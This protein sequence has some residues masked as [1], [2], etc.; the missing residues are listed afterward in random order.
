MLPEDKV[1]GMKQS[2]IER[3]ITK[4]VQPVIEDKGFALVSVTMK[5]GDLQIMAENPQTRN[6]G[7]DDCALLS[8]EISTLLEVEDPIKGR[9][10]L[11]ISSPGIDRP[12]VKLQDFA[13]FQ[14]LEAKIEINPPLEGQKKFRGRLKGTKDKEILIETD[15]ELVSLPFDS[16]EKA[17]LVLTDELIKQTAG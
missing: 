13:D 3:R 2:G 12:L 14:G 6:L 5:G 7:V 1:L 10:R 15:H 9:Y 17:K 4:L 16:I 8:R 11:E